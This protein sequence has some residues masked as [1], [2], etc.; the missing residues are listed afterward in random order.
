MNYIVL[1]IV[2]VVGIAI[3]M[4]FSRGKIN[5]LI[6]KQG[7]AHIVANEY[8]V[9]VFEPQIQEERKVTIKELLP[10]LRNVEV[11]GK[12]IK[13]FEVRSFKTASRE[14]RVANMTI[15]DETGS[16]RLVLWD[17]KQLQEVEAGNIKEGDIVRV[18]N[19]YVRS[20]QFSGNEVHMGNQATWEINP[21]GVAFSGIQSEA[22]VTMKHINELQ[23]NETVEVI[24]TVVQLFE[25]RFYDSCPECRKKVVFGEDGEIQ[26]ATH[27]K[28]EPVAQAILNMVFDDGTDNIRV[29]C[30]RELVKQVLEVDDVFVLRDNPDQF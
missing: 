20:N 2:A 19:G 17:E 26:C 7:A 25:P 16:C 4:Y 5:N 6:S 22:P 15:A 29:V 11:C 13:L 1:I 8:G 30:F 3:G 18:K 10:A 28:V 27:G 23:E 24:G 9:R 14:G 12:I 21:E